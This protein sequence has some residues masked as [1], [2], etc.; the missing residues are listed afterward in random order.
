MKLLVTPR[1]LMRPFVESDLDDLAALYADPQVM[2]YIGSG[3]IYSPEE[4]QLLLRQTIDDFEANSF[5]MLAVIERR[6]KRLIGR[7]GLK[8]L[9]DSDEV[10]IGFLLEERSWGKGFATEAAKE[11]MRHAFTDMK[12][13][14][15]IA[16]ADT[17]NIAGRR[18]LEKLGMKRTGNDQNNG[19]MKY[20]L[21]NNY[22]KPFAYTSQLS[23]LAYL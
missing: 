2:R 12:L 7:C 4:S 10:E 22:T 14:Y 13:S 15:L 1:L 17:R 11:V 9:N 21:R 19:S 18:V 5:G 8:P 3:S 6:E 20:E 16:F 23:S